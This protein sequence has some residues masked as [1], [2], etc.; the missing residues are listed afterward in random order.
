[1]KIISI[2]VFGILFLPH[3]S[4]QKLPGDVPVTF[5][6][7]KEIKSFKDVIYFIEANYDVVI[8]YNASQ[9]D[10]EATIDDIEKL[11]GLTVSK[12]IHQLLS[13]YNY[14]L[15]LQQPNK[16][17]ILIQ[18]RKSE[19]KLFWISGKI[20]ERATGEPISGALIIDTHH[21]SMVIAND[22]GYFTMEVP[23]GER[24]LEVRYIGYKPWVERI[25]VSSPLFLSP[26]LEVDNALPLITISDAGFHNGI[27]LNNSGEII[28]LYQYNEFR[29]VSGE[30]DPLNNTKVVPG[31]QSGGEGQS[32]LFVRGGNPSENLV[33]LD[34]MKVYEP[35]HIGGIASIFVNDMVKEAVVMKNGFPARYSG[36]LS[37]VLDVTLKNGNQSAHKKTI[38]FGLASGKIHAEGPIGNGKTTYNFALRS[39]VLRPYIDGVLRKFTKYDDIDIQYYDA[40]GKLTHAFSPTTQLSVSFYNGRDRLTLVKNDLLLSDDYLLNAYNRNALGWK[41]TMFSIKFNH[42]IKE[43]WVVKGQAGYLKYTTN[44]RSTYNFEK[45]EVDS[46]YQNALDVISHS[47]IEEYS[48]KGDIEFY[49]ND[50]HIFRSGVQWSRPMLNPTIKQS[51]VVLDGN[52][53]SIVDPDSVY[54]TTDINVYFEDNFKLGSKLFIY[55]GFNINIFNTEDNTTYSYLQP[56]LNMIYHPH[57]KHTITL[58]YSRMSQNIHLLSNHGIGLPSGLWVPNTKEV[59]PE[60]SSQWSA[61]YAIHLWESVHVSLGA[62]TKAYENAIE[63]T[64]PTDLFYTLL[65]SV[66]SNTIFN[67]YKDW[68]KNVFFGTA[69]SKGLEMIMHKR[70]GNTQ[71]WISATW[72]KTTR[73]FPDIDNGQPF[74]ST[75]D[76]TYNINASIIQNISDRWTVQ[77]QFVYA[78]GNTFS[79]ATE[80]FNSILDVQLLKSNGRNNYRLPPY[81]ALTVSAHYK[82]S[83]KKIDFHFDAS[84]YNVYNRLNA[85][86]IYIYRDVN[87]PDD[88]FLKKVSVLPVTPMVHFSLHF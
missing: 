68:Q 83:F 50:R 19:P 57:P 4:A 32:G 28:Q 88:Y 61:N 85:Y 43:R 12:I 18:G 25:D 33:L 81:H 15:I 70:S 53:A 20:T 34:G 75:Y 10:Q 87:N 44:N 36:H 13:D 51:L 40:I 39:S 56:R 35:S 24:N 86:Y 54:S 22:D 14:R 30:I 60:L 79:L 84:V 27:N 42:L 49:L 65:Q 66:P 67:Q 46:S 31:I 69:Q 21:Q 62:Y 6:D 37:S 23:A 38:S 59:Q 73:R 76:R 78:T 71:G 63:F 52:E 55:G 9:L 26:K 29:S 3:L 17:I 82:R 7:S 41:N 45:T 58:A 47:A 8:S 77:S 5:G 48:V 1:M 72:S 11:Q 80:E 74:P 16:F 64:A 2:L